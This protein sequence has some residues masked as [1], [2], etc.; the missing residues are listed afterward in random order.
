MLWCYVEIPLKHYV[1]IKAHPQSEVDLTGLYQR[2]VA[3]DPEASW[4]L[5]EDRK[6]LMNGTSVDKDRVVSELDFEVYVE[7]LAQV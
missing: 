2:L 3:L 5:H 4:F 1:R 6:Q 7:L